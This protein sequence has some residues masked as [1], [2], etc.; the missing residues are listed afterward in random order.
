VVPAG[1]GPYADRVA[2]LEACLVDAYDTIVTCDFSALRRE[3]PTLAGIPVSRQVSANLR[4]LAI[5]DQLMPAERDRLAAIG[6]RR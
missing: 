4:A 6:M 5:A 2:R 1:T 3:V